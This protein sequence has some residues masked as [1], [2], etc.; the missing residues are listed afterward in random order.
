[1]ATRR[2][3]TTRTA[4]E[5]E[6]ATSVETEDQAS[7]EANGAHDA[8]P[9]S[10]LDL[11]E[12]D[13]ADG[14]SADADANARATS[15]RSPKVKKEIELVVLWGVVTSIDSDSDGYVAILTDEE[16]AKD[17]CR[18]YEQTN[19]TQGVLTT[20]VQAIVVQTTKSGSGRGSRPEV[21]TDIYLLDRKLP[22]PF[23]IDETPIVRDFK[24]R[25]RALLKLTDEERKALGF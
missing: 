14:G 22:Q 10:A 23:D 1:M 18:F 12:G 16:E 25:Q 5:D 9:N 24:A 13:N 15:T 20:S 6:N 19:E 3:R 17:F 2:R 7:I 11:E 4:T 21:T 8:A